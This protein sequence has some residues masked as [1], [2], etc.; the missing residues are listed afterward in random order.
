MDQQSDRRLTRRSA[1]QAAG[2]IGGGLAVGLTQPRARRVSAQ[3]GSVT[4]P[5]TVAT[6]TRLA[7]DVWVWTNSG[8]NSLIITSD[9]GALVTEPSSQFNRGASTL[10]K[11]VVASLTPQPVKFVVFSH[12][13][14]DHNTGGD[15]F[16]DTAEFVSQELAAPKIAARNDPRSPVPTITFAEHMTLDLGGKEIELH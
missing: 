3:Q 13:H 9:E 15:V 7:Q 12:D 8:Y 6:L 16:A 11:A 10:L 5:Q 4:F 1:L 14:A 2:V